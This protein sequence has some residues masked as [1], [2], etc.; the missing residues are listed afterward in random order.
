VDGFFA[1]GLRVA[2]LTRVDDFAAEAGTDLPAAEATDDVLADDARAEVALLATA[3]VEPDRDP[4]ASAAAAA[5]FFSS[6]IVFIS[7]RK[8]RID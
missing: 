4:P 7:P 6:F 5:S 3:R 1:A 2:V 8:M